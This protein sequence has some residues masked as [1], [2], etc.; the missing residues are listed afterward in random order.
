MTTMDYTSKA[1]AWLN[2]DAIHPPEKLEIMPTMLDAAEGVL[3]A[4]AQFN[5]EYL[6][7]MHAYYER[8]DSGPEDL[9]PVDRLTG[10]DQVE[11]MLMLAGHIIERTVVGQ[12]SVT[13]SHAHELVA[14]FR[15]Q[16]QDVKGLYRDHEGGPF[17]GLHELPPEVEG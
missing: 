1:P 3:H 15:S 8:N 2:L 13:V 4:V 7:A 6:E 12:G 11:G 9:E 14:R 16:V 10:M 17:P 5:R